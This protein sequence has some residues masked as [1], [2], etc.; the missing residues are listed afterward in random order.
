MLSKS[1][2]IYKKFSENDIEIKIPKKLLLILSQQV[3]RC[4][5]QKNSCHE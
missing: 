3:S 4:I 2:E 1:E 5:T